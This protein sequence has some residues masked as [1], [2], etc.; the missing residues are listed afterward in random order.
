MPDSGAFHY[1]SDAVQNFVAHLEDRY[2]YQR[3]PDDM[4]PPTT[5]KHY[6]NLAIINREEKLKKE[7]LDEFTQLTIHGK[8][9]DIIKKKAPLQL[10]EIGRRDDGSF[11]KCILIEGAPGAGKT[12]LAWEICRNWKKTLKDFDIVLLLRMRDKSTQTA[13]HPSDLFC[14]NKAVRQEVYDDVDRANGQSLLIILEG[15]DEMPQHMQQNSIFSEII[16]GNILSQASV[17]VTSRPSS[18]QTVRHL[19][20]IENFQHIEVVGFTS[21]DIDN[22]IKDA[23]EGDVQL[24]EDF[25]KYLDLNPHIHTMMC[26]P[27]NCAIVVNVYQTEST[28]DSDVIPTTQTELYSTVTRKLVVRHLMKEDDQC[29]IQ[30]TVKRL[31][32]LPKEPHRQLLKLCKFAYDNIVDNKLVFDEIPP[33]IQFLGLV[34]KC[35]DLLSAESDSFNFIH[36]TLQEFLAAYYISHLSTRNIAH[37]FNTHS[38][39]EHMQVVLCFLSGLIDFRKGNVLLHLFSSTPMKILKSHC[40][41]PQSFLKAMHW[42]LEAQ[43]QQI[44]RKALGNRTQYHT[45]SGKIISPFDC[46]TL[47]YCVSASCCLWT[48]EL[49]SC[50]ITSEGFKTLC[51]KS[52]SQVKVLDLSQNKAADGG[53]LLGK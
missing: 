24:Q 33:D 44:A 49:K 30:K 20:P 9:D 37:C 5:G 19:C 25:H 47:S 50:N 13:Q 8:V 6:I 3:R 48:L 23:M 39:Q 22:Y 4:W 29:G 28:R 35:R 41:N 51:T 46:Y 43:D 40:K 45:L 27:L 10:E 42:L 15:Y 26:N 16:R 38:K 34:Q 12:T 11:I 1:T 32:D 52:L 17:M 21:R 2:R 53:I 14:S 7:E 18:S 31:S 36:L